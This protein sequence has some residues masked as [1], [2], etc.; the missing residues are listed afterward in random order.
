[1]NR[2]TDWE[3]ELLGLVEGLASDIMHDELNGYTGSLSIEEVES[4][5]DDGAAYGTYRIKANGYVI[6]V[7][8]SAWFQGEQD[9][10]D[11]SGESH[12]TKSV[13]ADELQDLEYEVK[14]VEK[15]PEEPAE[16]GLDK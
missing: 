8:A 7:E 13:T 2:R 12:Y 9:C 14:K 11:W 10:Y 1:M 4:G 15:E 16:L 6:T 5:T 3:D